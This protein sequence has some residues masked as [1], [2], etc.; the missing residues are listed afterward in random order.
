MRE[1]KGCLAVSCSI[2]TSGC[3]DSVIKQWERLFG[4]PFVSLIREWLTRFCAEHDKD[5]EQVLPVWID[6]FKGIDLEV[7][8]RL[9]RRAQRESKFF[10]KIA[11]ILGFLQKAEEIAVPQAAEEAWQYALKLR[12]E[13]WN[14]D[15]P[16]RLAA[17]LRGLPERFQVACRASGVFR[18]FESL[19]A[20]HTW[21]KKPFIE[22]F[23]DY[24]KTERDQFLLAEGNKVKCLLAA[25]PLKSLPPPR[26][27]SV[28]HKVAPAELAARPDVVPSSMRKVVAAKHVNTSEQL[29]EQAAAI[30]KRFPQPSKSCV[31]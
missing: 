27:R 10:P 25:S 18:D 21:A 5:I 28:A 7:L 12:R 8:E 31:A 2:T 29:K 16:S 9:F 3:S 6:A 30:L 23:M 14:P 4:E 11:E 22:T 19:E 1:E 17:I 24:V 15:L 13:E 26:E 20:L